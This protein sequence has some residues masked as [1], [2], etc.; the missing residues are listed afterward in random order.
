ML[1]RSEFTSALI[2]ALHGENIHVA[3]ETTGCCEEDVFKAVALKADLLLFDFKHH[4]SNKHREFTAVGTELI[5]K[6]L[7]TAIESGVEVLPRIP[8]IPGFNDSLEDAAKMAEMLLE[9]GAKKAQLLP[10]H[11]F[12]ENKYRALGKI[13]EY[14]NVPALHE[15]ELADYLNIFITKGIEAFF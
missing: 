11:Q 14:E 2:D 6:N 13:Y 3:L 4:D 12:G 10:F 15:E 9:F 7:K 8:V 1:F 5:H